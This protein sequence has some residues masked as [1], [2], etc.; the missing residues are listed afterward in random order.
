MF[1]C[2][3]CTQASVVALGGLLESLGEFSCSHLHFSE[4]RLCQL[5]EIGSFPHGC[6]REPFT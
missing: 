1:K 2:N 4:A 5:H 3:G 6:I